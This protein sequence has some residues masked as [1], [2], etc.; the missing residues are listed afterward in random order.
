MQTEFFYRGR[1]AMA[2]VLKSFG[3]NS[4]DKIVIQ[5]YTCI[6]VPQAISALG[7]VPVVVDTENSLFMSP[8]L[9][10]DELKK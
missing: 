1:W 10:E 8:Y 4:G 3:L 7:M 5:G 9:L 2:A 6:A